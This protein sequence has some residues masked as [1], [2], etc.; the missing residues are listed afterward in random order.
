MRDFVDHVYKIPHR[1]SNERVLLTKTFAADEYARALTSWQWLGV[2]GK[3]P[4]LSSLFGDTFMQDADGYWF[5]D[6][7]E[8]TL[9]LTWSTRDELQ[10]DLDSEEGQ[11]KYLMGAFAMNRTDAGMTL[12]PSDVYAFQVPPRLGGPIDLSNVTVMPFVVIMHILGQ[13]H[14]QVN[15]P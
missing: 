6:T 12:G 3:T 1:W 14:E 10:A 11:D 8:G 15:E 4:V 7:L 13:V 2:Q 9:E 5:L